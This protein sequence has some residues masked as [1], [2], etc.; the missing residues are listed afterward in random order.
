MAKVD[1]KL[2]TAIRQAKSGEALQAV[3]TIRSDDPMPPDQADKRARSMVKDASKR[4]SQK[5]SRLEVFPNLQS[6]AVEADAQLIDDI[7]G[8]DDIDSASLNKP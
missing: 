3:F 6:F 4:T 1:P 7:L 2:T 8:Q 5:P